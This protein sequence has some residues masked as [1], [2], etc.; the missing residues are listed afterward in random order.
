VYEAA[1]PRELDRAL[2]ELKPAVLLLDL[3]LRGVHRVA[4]LSGLL[5]FSSST[6]IVFLT[7]R[8][9]DREAILAL[10]AGARGYCHR[11]IPPRQ[12][13]KAVERIRHGEIWIGR[14]VIGI[15]LDELT[16][17]VERRYGRT[18]YLPG[19]GLEDPDGGDRGGHLEIRSPVDRL[20]PREEEIAA[21]VKVGSSNKE[22]ARSLYLSEKTVK[23][24]LTAIF[25][26]FGISSRLQL[27]LILSRSPHG[28]K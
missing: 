4:G 9:D 14:K 26:K 19:D 1:R 13:R 5:Q 24:R 12:L 23:A 7:S 2:A 6:K 10:R 28:T 8:P 27:G 25:Q 22:I 20:T 21:L 15:L 11:S 18:A 16:A 3:G 17:L